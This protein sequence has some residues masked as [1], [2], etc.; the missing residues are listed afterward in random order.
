MSSADLPFRQHR[1]DALSVLP[2]TQ[3]DIVFIGNSITNMHEWWEAFGGHQ[4]ILNRGVSGALSQEALEHLDP[5]IAGQPKKV[6]LMLGTND[7]GTPGYNT[8]QQIIQN[9]DKIITRFQQ[10]SPCT[11]LYVQSILPSKVGLRTLELESATNLGLAMLCKKRNVTFIDLWDDFQGVATLEEHTLDGLHLM[12]SGYQIWC[13]KI[14]P[15][16]GHPTVYPEET[17]SLQQSGGLGRSYGMRNTYFSMYPI[18]DGDILMMG[19]EMIHGGEWHELLA[20]NKVKNR[21]MG[22]GYPGP[23]LSSIIQSVP[24]IFNQLEGQPESV[25]IYA[26]TAEI[27]ANVKLDEVV[28]NYRELVCRIH[29]IVP[30]TRICLM[31]LL[32]TDNQERNTSR[33][34]PFNQRLS[35]LAEGL[36]LVDYVDLYDMMGKDQ[37]PQKKYFMGNYLNGEGY[38]R[39]A[40]IISEQLALTK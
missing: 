19:D 29:D 9:I 32:P 38:V 24:I 4:H 25:F 28:D 13:K 39:V 30:H 31:G 20:N 16:V 2:V 35:L 27:N 12:A 1:Y 5:I 10:E 15:F 18:Q 3:A 8:P 23:N 33:V 26:G 6:F 22:W 36:E 7:L 11:E 40:K 34:V 21:G 14:A 37:L 17:L